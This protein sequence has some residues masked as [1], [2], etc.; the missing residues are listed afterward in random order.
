LGATPGQAVS[1]T[2]SRAP[3]LFR[4]AGRKL[5]IDGK[6]VRASGHHAASGERAPEGT[7]VQVTGI[8][9]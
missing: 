2:V 7:G 4:N 6:P 3:R 5:V 9:G 1:L 8:V